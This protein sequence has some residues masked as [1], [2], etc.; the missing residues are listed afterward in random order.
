LIAL[1]GSG[2]MQM[3][4]IFPH[5]VVVCAAS[6]VMCIPVI[7][8]HGDAGRYE[9]TLTTVVGTVVELQLVN[10]HSML[11]IDS[12]DKNG[13]M[14]RWRGE[15]GAP[16]GLKGWCWDKDTFKAGDKITMIG[17]RLKNGQPYMTLSENARVI[18]SRGKEVF[19][20]NDPGKRGEPG[21]CAG[22]R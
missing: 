9:D 16:N 17:R 2:D 21:P 15:L 8:H 7:A 11:I 12:P 19:R 13:K 10:P 14:V 18:D 5:A 4:K 1:N 3:K 22:Q 6:I 20:G